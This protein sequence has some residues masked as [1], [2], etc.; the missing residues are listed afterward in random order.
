M[1]DLTTEIVFDEGETQGLNRSIHDLT[2]KQIWYKAFQRC[3]D[4]GAKQMDYFYDRNGVLISQPDVFIN[5]VRMFYI[6]ALGTLMQERFKEHLTEI[7]KIDERIANL[8]RE[9]KED[10]NKLIIEYNKNVGKN[11]ERN[12]NLEQNTKAI[13]QKYKKMIVELNWEKLAFL[14]IMMEN[15]NY[16]DTAGGINN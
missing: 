4:E 1:D 7:Q 16:L 11:N 9:N 14:S 8:E 3:F 10:L 15:E 12:I 13:N 5:S 2:K 6:M